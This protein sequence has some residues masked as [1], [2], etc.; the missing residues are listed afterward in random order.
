MMLMSSVLSITSQASMA[1]RVSISLQAAFQYSYLKGPLIAD[2]Q[3]GLSLLLALV[4][5]FKN[6]G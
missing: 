1:S 2:F 6:T 5:A 3:I 4:L